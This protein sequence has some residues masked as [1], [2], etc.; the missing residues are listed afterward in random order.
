[1][2]IMFPVLNFDF[3]SNFK[4][5][6]EIMQNDFEFR[7]ELHKLMLVY[8]VGRYLIALRAEMPAV[9]RPVIKAVTIHCIEIMY[10]VFQIK[11]IHSN[12]T[13]IFCEQISAIALGQCFACGVSYFAPDHHSSSTMGT[14]R[15]W[16]NTRSALLRAI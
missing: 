7:K 8:L 4:N 6:A 9:R 3:Y 11:D 1:V 10:L 2:I 14:D 5:V 15:R 12:F 13:F 16:S